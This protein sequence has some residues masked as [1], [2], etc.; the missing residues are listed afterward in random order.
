MATDHRLADYQRATTPDE[1]LAAVDALA[2]LDDG[3]DLPL[4]DLYDEIA[5]RFADADRHADAAAAQRK[6]LDHGYAGVPDGREMLAWYLLK[7][8]QREEADPLW[9][10]LLAERPDDPDLLLTA[11]VAH[12]DAEHWSEAAE[13]LA[14][15]MKGFLRS[16][17]DATWLREAIGE[18]A[19]V[20]RK[21]G[22]GPEPIDA[23]AA[24]T[25]Q[26]LE[27]QAEGAPI[28]TPWYPASEYA[29][30]LERLPAFGADWSDHD[31]AAY[32]RELDRRLREV[33]GVH[34]R[35]PVIVPVRV[36]AYVTFAEQAGLDPEWAETRARFADEHRDEAITWPPG[37]N[38]P[39]WCGA[40]AKYK[41]HCGA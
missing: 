14:A 1:A 18:R 29:A 41:R 17:L 38:D 13:F 11:G 21:L 28:A 24:S 35:A 15:A 23:H 25:M 16:S 2:A 3:H 8:G 22:R 32:S 26:R 9:R 19:A 12:R 5:D 10:E 37:R 36:A 34:G 7:A 39:C 4:G 20:L 30:A 31:H 40:D 6:A 27:R 33:G